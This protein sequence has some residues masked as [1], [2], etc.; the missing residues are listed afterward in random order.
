MTTL[1]TVTVFL[2]GGHKMGFQ[3]AAVLHGQPA[4][5]ALLSAFEHACATG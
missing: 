5:L 1:I 2:W 4:V 3:A